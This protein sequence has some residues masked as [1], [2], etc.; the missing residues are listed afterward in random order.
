MIILQAENITAG[1][2][3]EVNILYEVGIRLKSGQIVS[4]IGPNGAG[5]STL[6]KTIFGILKPSNGKISLKEEDITGLKPDKVANK[7]ISY[8]P[9]VEN[10]FPSLTIQENLE[11]GAFIRDDDY[12]QRLNEIYE[13]FPILGDRR[14][15]K[16]G[17]LSGGQRQMVA[18][19][20]ALMVDPQVLLLD[21]PSAGLSPKLVDMIFEKIIDI[22]KSGVSMIIVEQNAREALKMA[23]HGYVL[24]MGRNVLDD[25]FRR[26]GMLE[27]V[28]YGIVFGSIISLGAIGL[29]L[30]FGIIRFAN[31]AHGDLMSSGAY[32][33]LFMVTGLLSWIGVP[34]TTFGSL[35]FGWRMLIAFPVSMFMVGCVAIAADRIL[36]RKLR[37]NKSSP[38]MLAMSSL[39]V[40]FII[41]MLILIFWGADS[42]FYRPGLMRPALELPLGV[43]IRPDQILILFVVLSLVVLLHLYLQKTKMGKAMRATADNMELALVSGIDTERVIILTWGVGGALAAAG[44][45][46][47]GIDV[48]VHAYMGWNFLIPL[49]A[50]T[51]LGTIGN[52]WGALVGG[53]VIGVAQQVSTAFLLSTYKPAVAFMLMILILLIRPKGIFGGKQE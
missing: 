42:L 20:R 34:D 28:V 33:A 40:A 49:F 23:D 32:F 14:K 11:M 27:L 13:L 44:G 18:M 53:L 22:N 10:V 50:A 35:S 45:I 19:G 9:Q 2:T 31:F 39:G 1:Y 7:G 6:L 46:L 24:A 15:Q 8:V 38:V 52:M 17:Q 43:K 36:Y 51:I 25:S 12:S 3:R 29:T 4:V 5:K 21:E 26:V 16:A 47:Y 30:V 37:N 48:Q 41:R